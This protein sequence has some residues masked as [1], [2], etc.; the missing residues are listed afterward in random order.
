M[1]IHSIIWDSEIYHKLLFTSLN[2]AQKHL[3]LNCNANRSNDM[4]RLKKSTHLRREIK[5]ILDP[6]VS[7]E[8]IITEYG[9]HKYRVAFSSGP[10]RMGK[11][12]GETAQHV[13]HVSKDSADVVQPVSSS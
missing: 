10:S 11:G 1:S 6:R 13:V 4:Y 3:K 12:E 7:S 9:V 5:A 8:F 2:G